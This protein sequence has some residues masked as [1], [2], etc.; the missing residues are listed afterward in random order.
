MS[1]RSPASVACTWAASSEDYLRG[2]LLV[3]LVDPIQLAGLRGQCGPIDVGI[4]VLDGNRL[5]N[6]ETVASVERLETAILGHPNLDDD[7]AGRLLA[8]Y[9][10]A[11]LE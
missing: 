6:L 1:T 3:G 2:L 4:V 11:R 7:L 5:V 8:D 9:W 10:A